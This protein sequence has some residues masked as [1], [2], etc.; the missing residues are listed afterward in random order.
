ML[1]P[2]DVSGLWVFLLSHDSSLWTLAARSLTAIAWVSVE[3]RLTGFVLVALPRRARVLRLRVGGQGA[4]VLLNGGTGRRR[5]EGG[6]E[7]QAVA[8]GPPVLFAL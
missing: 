7:A 6:A 4:A 2:P 8:Q 3:A 1:S 5:G